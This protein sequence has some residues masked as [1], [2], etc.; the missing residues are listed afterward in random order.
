MGCCGSKEKHRKQKSQI[1]E[2]IRNL[3]TELEEKI[4]DLRTEYDELRNQLEECRNQLDWTRVRSN[5]GSECIK[6]RSF[7]CAQVREL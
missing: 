7:A 3:K 6:N 4:M 5:A 2:E 1:E